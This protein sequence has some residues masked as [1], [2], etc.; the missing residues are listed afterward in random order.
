M[1]TASIWVTKLPISIYWMA[2]MSG[3]FNSPVEVPK[4]KREI[5]FINTKVMVT[6]N[7]DMKDHFFIFF[8]SFNLGR[9][10]ASTIN[11]PNQRLEKYAPFMAGISPLP[12]M[13]KIWFIFTSG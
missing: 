13:G 9:K 11:S 2:L 6:N 12:K 4:V 7:K 8:W 5:I 10:K 3:A 1:T